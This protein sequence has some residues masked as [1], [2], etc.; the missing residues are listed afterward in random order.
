[1]PDLEESG[2]YGANEKY[3]EQWVPELPDE[4]RDPTEYM[5]RQFV[6]SVDFK[7]VLCFRRG[8]A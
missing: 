7:A 5:C 8:Q 6:V 3:E 1:L 4:D 2:H